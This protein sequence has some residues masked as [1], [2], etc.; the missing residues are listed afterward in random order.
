MVKVIYRIHFFFQYFDFDFLLSE[1]STPRTPAPVKRV[2]SDNNDNGSGQ[3]LNRL[4]PK[5]TLT[6]DNLET[7]DNM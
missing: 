6:N 3:T 2:H 5:R 4:G 1:G 7:A